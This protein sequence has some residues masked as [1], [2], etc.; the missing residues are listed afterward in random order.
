MKKYSFFCLLILVFIVSSPFI[1]SQSKI[2]SSTKLEKVIEPKLYS[3]K[4]LFQNVSKKLLSKDFEAFVYFFS[5][6]YIAYDEMVENGFVLDDFIFDIRNKMENDVIKTSDDLIKN[7]YENLKEYI[8]DSHFAIANQNCVYYFNPK[9]LKQRPDLSNGFEIKINS[10]SVYLS[11]PNFLPEF[12][13][14]NPTAKEYFEKVYAELKNIKKKKYL[15]IDLRNCPGGTTDYPLLLLYSLYEGTESVIPSE[16]YDIQQ[17]ESEMMLRV[18]ES[19]ET[20]VTESLRY[21]RAIDTGNTKY[22]DF[23]RI[24]SVMQIKNPKRI[25]RNYNIEPTKK[26]HKPAYKGKIIFLT[27][28]K[29]A[30]AAESLILLSKVLFPKNIKIIGENTMGCLT[31]VDV[32]QLIMP[33]NSFAISMAF[34]SIEETLKDFDC[35]KGEGIG[36]QPDIICPDKDIPQTLIKITKDKKLWYKDCE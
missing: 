29:T 2:I 17:L 1:F 26:L 30:S 3:E 11:L 6:S 7:I 34:K 8:C 20:P 16:I 24:S 25:V 9:L 36:I 10:N 28:N 15:I 31:Y 13:S 12:F 33:N 22:E 27:N 5:T 19:I 21:Q 23:F 14:E 18:S 32:F 35:W 4:T